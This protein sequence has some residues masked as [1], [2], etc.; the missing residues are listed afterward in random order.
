M[1]CLHRRPTTDD[2]MG[3]AWHGDAALLRLRPMLA[4]EGDPADL[5]RDGFAYEI[6]WDGMRALAHVDRAGEL[7]LVN[8]R[9]EEVAARY[10]ELH[11]PPL[12]DAV[13]DGEVIAIGP[14]GRPSFALLQRR[15]RVGAERRVHIA[16]LARRVPVA[17]V[18]FDCLAQAGRWLGDEPYRARR[19]ALEGL[20]L[21][22]PRWQRTPAQEGGG[23]DMMRAVRERG[24]EGLVA[25]AVDSPYLPGRRSSWWRKVR[26]R[27]R[28]EFA[29]A[30]WSEQPERRGRLASL[31]LAYRDEAGRWRYAG[32]VGAG[33]RERDRV[34]LRR[35]LAARE[36]PRN[37]LAEEPGHPGLHYVAPALVCEVAFANWT[38]DGRLRQPSFLGLREDKTAEEVRR[39]R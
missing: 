10:P 30:G 13:V 23:R 38:P 32:R 29:I 5:D 31:V 9:G 20:P 25:K 34:E 8:R 26:I 33:L 4:V 7:R 14:D 28:Q 6:K 18:A 1:P 22:D 36:I 35:A 24:L 12:R 2:R 21:A 16:R 37:P 15:M 3:I 39:E 27:H 19:R 17:Y 11:R